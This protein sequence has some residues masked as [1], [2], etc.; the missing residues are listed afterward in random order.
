MDQNASNE[1]V[2]EFSHWYPGMI[3]LLF[4]KYFQINILAE[5]PFSTNMWLRPL[6]AIIANTNS[7]S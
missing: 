3:D 4:T 5:L 2:K 1:A 7:A 6:E